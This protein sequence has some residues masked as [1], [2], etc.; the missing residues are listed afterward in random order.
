VF[1]TPARTPILSCSHLDQRNQA[2]GGAGR[3]GDHR[4][5]GFQYP[6]I[7]AVHDGGIDIVAAGAEI[8]TFSRPP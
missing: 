6:V 4:H 8:T 7:H 5:A 2:I 1:I 3:I